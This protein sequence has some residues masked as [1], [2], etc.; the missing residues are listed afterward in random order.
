MIQPIPNPPNTKPSVW[1]QWGAENYPDAVKNTALMYADIATTK[2]VA[3]QNRETAKLSGWTIKAFIPF[4]L[5]EANWTPFAQRLQD[6][7]ITA[8]SVTGSPE[9]IVGLLKA[10]DDVGYRPELILQEANFYDQKMLR[11]AG[12]SA[13]G[14]FVRTAYTPF[15]E[16]EQPAMKSYLDMMETYK[17]D[18]KIGGLGL[19][20]TSAFLMFATAANECLASNDGVLERECVLAAGKGITSWTG[21][22]LHAETNPSENLPPL[23]TIIMEVVDGKWQRA[24]PALDSEDNNADGWNCRDNGRTEIPGKYGDYE[25]GV[26]PSRE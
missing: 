13:E 25:L 10:M 19:Q 12:A 22:G 17:P 26:D 11:S 15:E 5:G 21:G 8:V 9:E 4:A 24:Y 18:G 20:A 7:K 3:E 14:M 6:E 2:V 23:C 1:W 16:P